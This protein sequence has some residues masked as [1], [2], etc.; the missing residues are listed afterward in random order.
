MV[1][2]GKTGTLTTGE[3]TIARVV[4]PVGEVTVTGAGYRPEGRLEHDGVALAQGG[5][6]WRQTV[7]IL[8]AGSVAADATLQ[9][10]DG[11]WTVLGD[12]IEG[13]FLVADMKT[14]ARSRWT[15]PV[16][17][18]QRNQV[19]LA[20]RS[21]DFRLGRRPERNLRGSKQG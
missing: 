2:S 16:S 12:P 14:G 7:L 20:K 18:L 15:T 9:Q 8:R 13:A 11:Q 10:Q 17:A 6:L 19:C 3:M 21:P 5:D 1:C 4:T